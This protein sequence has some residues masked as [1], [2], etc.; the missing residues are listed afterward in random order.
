MKMKQKKSSFPWLMT[1]KG[2]LS[3]QRFDRRIAVVLLVSYGLALLIV[4]AATQ[5]ET[6]F[7]KPPS[8][9]LGM[10]AS[11]DIVVDRDIHY[12]DEEATSIL[13]DA[14][15]KLVPPVFV[16]NDEITQ[17]SIESFNRFKKSVFPESDDSGKGIEE[18]KFFVQLQRDFPDIIGKITQEEIS[19]LLSADNKDEIFSMSA[20]LLEK[21]MYRGLVSFQTLL[22]QGSDLFSGGMIEIWHSK[23]GKERIPLEE[24][25][26]P[27]RL[28][29]WV[30]T[31][32][33]TDS[34]SEVDKNLVYLLIMMFAK[35]NAF[36]NE[37]L[38][39]MERK[40]ARNEVTDVVRRLVEGQVIVRKGDIIDEESLEKINA[41]GESV[42]AVNIN[43]IAGTAFFLG[44]LF[45][46]S[47][48]LLN[49]QFFSKGFTLSQIYFLIGTALT[50]LVVSAFLVQ[51][52][53]NSDWL[54]F[55]VII[56][57]GM[58]SILITMIVSPRVGIISSLVLSLL[59][60]IVAR[61]D[62]AA[63]LF[64][65]FSGAAGCAVALKAER[66]ID[67]VRAGLALTL[68]N[69]LIL[70][71]MGFLKNFTVSELPLA[72][73]WGG[74]NGFFSGILSLGFLPIIEH[75]MNAPTRFRLMELSDL[76]APIFKRMLS[77]APGTYNHSILVANMAESACT[78]IGANALLA[79]VGAYY[80]DIGKIDQSSYFIENQREN[81]RHDD[82]KPSL[83]AAVI[84]SHVKLG[85]EKGKELGL[86]KEV[87]DVIAQHHGKGV[88]NYFYQR[89][90]EV[91]VKEQFSYDDFRYSGEWPKTKEGAVVMLAD[92]VEA[93]SRTLKKPTIAKLKK[94]F[95]AIIMER[96]KAGGFNQSNLTFND[97][98]KI[99]DSFVHF[100]SGYLHSRIEYPKTKEATQ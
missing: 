48:F 94:T 68:F 63:F 71:T 20:V 51:I 12:V 4:I 6:L 55:S 40:R 24:I 87:I 77:L 21:I 57:V 8:V 30:K 86:P 25:V 79:R 16:M 84:K 5:K 26:T 52:S 13:K 53:W 41:I 9:D 42:I 47:I 81:N 70:V 74:A 90:L 7:V 1:V 32:E 35:E 28:K 29:D 3:K 23:M 36:F 43:S 18:N 50:Y 76:N 89:A 75:I 54:P 93:V 10:V 2:W 56:P 45:V 49:K 33:R 27:D 61:M 62:V 17:D 46:F 69:T 59:L 38:T 34:F 83:S 66:R 82:L 39:E 15:E 67:L 14:S 92:A 100:I 64:A 58:F 78:Q 19:F 11:E 22:D 44:L 99:N 85:V 88:I 98:E 80:H 73:A 91:E 72:L 95:W 37:A 60:L 97:L 96:F 65:L 31:H